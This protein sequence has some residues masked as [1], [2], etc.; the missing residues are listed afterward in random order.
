MIWLMRVAGLALD[1]GGLGA[2]G[3]LVYRRLGA[4]LDLPAFVA[5]SWRDILAVDSG[6]MA[7]FAAGALLLLSRSPSKVFTP[8]K[9][10]STATL[11]HPD[12]R[13]TA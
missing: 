9:R 3:F 6:A 4:A 5:P 2:I 10:L 13:R 1:A 7:A 11:S 12:S 8:R